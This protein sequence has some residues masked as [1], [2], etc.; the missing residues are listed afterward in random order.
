MNQT[1]QTNRRLIPANK[2]NEH[3]EWPPMGGLRHLIFHADSNGF[4]KVV[5]RCGRRVLID[6]GAFFDWI[7]NQPQQGGSTG[8]WCRRHSAKSC[9]HRVR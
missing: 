8:R 2:W 1:K 4:H 7:E 3:H 9:R 5:R 6:E